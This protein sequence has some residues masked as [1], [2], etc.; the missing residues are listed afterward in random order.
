MIFPNDFL[1]GGAAAANQYEGG[2]NED[3][4][5]PSTADMMTSG[6][7]AQSRLITREWEKDKLYPN[8]SATDFYHHYKEDISLMAEM[9]FKAYRMSIA[10]TRIF[11]TGM[12]EIPNEKG[13]LFYDKV[14]D[15]LEKYNIQSIV[16]ISHYEMPF[17][18]TKKYNGWA[19]RK[20]IDYYIRFCKTIFNR[21]KN[22]VKYWITFNE[23]NSG[24]TPFGNFIAL[25]ILNEG[26]REATKQVDIPTLRF[27][28]LHHQFIA[29]ALAVK[30]GHKINKE[31]KIGC[32]SAMVPSYPLT[33]H[34]QDSLLSLKHWRRMNYY[35]S[36]V[37]LR[38]YYPFYTKQIWKEESIILDIRDED[39]KILK[40]GIADFYAISYYH[41]TCVSH[42]KVNAKTGGNLIAGVENPYLKA[43]DWGWQIDPDA[44]RYLLNV[45]YDRYN[46]P[47]MIVENG[48]GAYD[49]VEN[50]GSIHDE[51]RI[52]YLR[53]HIKAMKLAIEDGVDLIGYTPW[54]CIDIISMS[55]GEMAKRYGFVYVNK[56]DDGTGD[57]TRIKKDS[58]YWYK[59]V[60]KSN[61]EILK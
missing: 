25:G 37:Q 14:F 53:E 35:C 59:N 17:E 43:N 21:Y 19:S 5:G 47:I 54:G 49:A 52:D 45:L 51:Y 1:W 30:I 9:G 46:V 56:Q 58:F 3:G 8:H 40:E 20:V 23:I 18:L 39:L 42:K 29:S 13:L 24:T 26:T 6:S 34:P 10:W 27:Q 22:R 38:G 7:Y 41:S 61:G 2:W 48:L 57:Y 4:K 11:P 12:E 28:A 15:E 36:D 16:T 55:T 60:I 44:L 33:C 32:M 31:F 50:D